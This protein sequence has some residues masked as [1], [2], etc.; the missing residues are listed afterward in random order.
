M[1]YLLILSLAVL[2]TFSSVSNTKPTETF[3]INDDWGKTGHRAVGEIASKHLSRKARKAINDLLDGTSLAEVSIYADEIRSDSKYRAYGPWHYVNVPFDTTYA[4]A[5]KNPNGDIIVAINECIAK[6]KDEA[7]SKD[8]RAFHLK[9]LVHFIGDLH[10]PLHTGR[11]EDKGGND[12][13]VRWF[14]EG[15][16]LHRVWDSEMI[17]FY[18]MS[19]SELSSNREDLTK[20]QIKQWQAGSVI[21]WANESRA[22]V[23]TVYKTA[24]SG[25]KLGYVYMYENFPLV[26]TQLHKSGLRLAKILNNI[27]G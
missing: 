3:T 19:Y 7:L 21:D 12:I 9:L 20:T 8:D 6:V 18:K 14:G 27:L 2:T 4:E 25:D 22:L 16:N 1:K 26:R 11:S 10:Q 13:Q 23:Q 5:E 17:D 15:S 24:N